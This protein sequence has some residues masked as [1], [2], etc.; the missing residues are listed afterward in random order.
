M[1]SLS[2]GDYSNARQ[3]IRLARIKRILAR[4]GSDVNYQQFFN[5][6][7]TLFTIVFMVHLLAC[8]FYLVPT[9]AFP[10]FSPGLDNSRSNST[11]KI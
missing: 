3:M 4:H 5:I 11:G 1:L 6:A 2:C 10:S 9:L 8:F 7:F